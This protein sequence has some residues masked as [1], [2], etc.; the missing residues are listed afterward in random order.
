MADPIISFQQFI[1]DDEQHEDIMPSNSGSENDIDYTN[2]DGTDSDK[3]IESDD[4][5]GEIEYTGLK[6][7]WLSITP[8]RRRPGPKPSRR[9]QS[10]ADDSSDNDY[11][12]RTCG[13][14]P[15]LFVIIEL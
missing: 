12:P 2:K 7:S 13:M 9:K 4:S 11:D 15:C 10:V 1:D 3:D 8:P 5:D 6:R 14:F